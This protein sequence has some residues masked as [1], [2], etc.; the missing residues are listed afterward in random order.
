MPTL[1]TRIDWAGDGAFTQ[2]IDDVSVYVDGDALHRVTRGRS[3]DRSGD[4]TGAASFVLYNADDRYT[5]DR[6]WCDNPSFE[7]GVAGW[8]TLAIASLVAAA[9]S[10]TQV[11]DNAPAAGTKAGEAVLTA[12]L[13]SGVTYAI[14]YKF[15]SGIAYAVSVYLKSMSGALTVRAG[16]ASSGTPADIASSGADITTSWAAYT[17]TWTPSADRTDAVFFVRTTAA[18]AATV[19]IDAVQVNPGTVANPYLEA[20]TKGQLVPG[21]PVH[22]YATHSATDY[23]Q[24]YGYIE[25]ITP[26]PG[27]KT[28]EITCYDPLRRMQDETVATAFVPWTRS[29]RDCRRQA[30]EEYERGS[31][32]LVSNPAFVTDTAGWQASGGAMITR[33]AAGGPTVETTCA[34][35]VGQGHV[36]QRVALASRFPT[37]YIYRLSFYA[38]SISGSTTLS[39]YAAWGATYI[40]PTFTITGDW[41]RYSFTFTPTINCDAWAGFVTSDLWVG[42]FLAASQTVRVAAINLTRGP[43]LHP[44]S[45]VG[46]GRAPNLAES[47]DFDLIAYGWGNGFT[48][49]VTNGSF[50]TDTAGWSVAANAFHTV[51]TSI[52]RY[53]T[54]PK[55][56]GWCSYVDNPGTAG[57]GT[58]FAIT[59]TFVAG[60]GYRATGWARVG[61]IL[62]IGIGSNGTPADFAQ[63]A[64][65]NCAAGWTRLTVNWTPSANRTDAHLYFKAANGNDYYLDGAMV[66]ELELDDDWFATGPHA[67]LSAATSLTVTTNGDRTVY[68]IACPATVGA[69]ASYVLEDAKVRLV[70]GVQYYLGLD[71][72]GSGSCSARVGWAI[73]KG[74]GTF[75]EGYGTVA[76]TT[77]WQRA[78]VEFTPTATFLDISGLYPADGYLSVWANDTTASTLYID[79]VR[80]A[81]E[82]AA[83]DFMP[84]QWVLPT[85]TEPAY[86]VSASWQGWGSVASVLSGINA[87]V[88]SN[89]YIAPTMAAPWYEYRVVDIAARNAATSAETYDNEGDL[90]GTEITPAAFVNTQ[91][92]QIGSAM[93]EYV[94]DEASVGLY[95]P[96]LGST[97]AGSLYADATLPAAVAAGIVARYRFPRTCPTMVVSN[98]FPSQLQ[99][100]LDEMVTVNHVRLG[101][102][103][104]KYLISRLTTWLTEGGTIWTTSYD[105]EEAP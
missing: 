87:L 74:D 86:A 88:G 9:T 34:E 97:L 84:S 40:L 83:A 25:R 29:V 64:N 77:D 28:V 24:F 15:R 50:E 41:V 53:N 73:N 94:S 38:K 59:G 103:G 92:Y 62:A 78:V 17:F 33:V 21:R 72:K 22:T 91:G 46:V 82:A 35:L 14:P 51:S 27:D 58:H 39:G 81:A 66:A 63:G 8:S 30:L 7:A 1:T 60:R 90:N 56:G 6:N 31:Y 99:R 47:G 11:T 57:S 36:M 52:T 16:L 37:G 69:G 85:G 102:R 95:G 48:N 93:P 55:Y 61:S 2:A 32:N 76:V 101:I 43:Q 5:P 54:S 26:R 23:P 65:T 18:A 75:E 89:H 42:L 70:G 49:L 13:N 45:R 20:P 71:I 12:T 96:Q 67:G 79:R 80:L 44:Y 10:I 104:G 4:A 19:R 98:R 3:A 100:S 68:A 105:L